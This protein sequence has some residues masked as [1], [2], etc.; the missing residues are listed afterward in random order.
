MAYLRDIEL[1]ELGL[2]YKNTHCVLELITAVRDL[3]K[4]NV[5]QKEIDEE[6]AKSIYDALDVFE[7]VLDDDEKDC[8]D[9]ESALCNFRDVLIADLR[10]FKK[11][12]H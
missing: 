11:L 6:I 8:I 1:D 9:R 3:R 5:A 12:V 10:H 4:N 7:E 2:K